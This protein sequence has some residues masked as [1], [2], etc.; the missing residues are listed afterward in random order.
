MPQ[1]FKLCSLGQVEEVRAALARGE[2][3]NSR[4]AYNGTP[5]IC[6]VSQCSENHVSILR[7]LLE[8]PSIEV[9]LADDNSVTALQAAITVGNNE[10]V[11]LLLEHPS[12]EVNLATDE[13]VTALSAAT[14]CGNTEGVKL[15]LAG[16]PKGGCEQSRC[17]QSNCANVYSKIV[18]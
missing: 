7:L 8:Q 5:L 16:R 3:A 1:L 2:D 13:G 6:A 14:D 4:D 9:N 17:R 18:Q 10:A 15:L 11:K 12:I